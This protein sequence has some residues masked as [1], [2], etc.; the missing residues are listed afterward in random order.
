MKNLLKKI[1]PTQVLSIYH[2]FIAFSS[3][4]FY[5]Q[6]AKKLKII[7]V[8]GTK[9]KTST[10]EI[11]NSL[12][13]GAGYKTAI[14]STLRFKIDSDSKPN[15]LK[16]T[17]PGR[18]FLQKFLKEAL[19]KKVTHVIVEMS[20]EGVKQFRHSFID[21]DALVVTNLSPEHIEAHG[22][23]EHYALAKI[24]IVR[25]LIY[26]KKTPKI[27]VL[28]GDD[29]ES[30]RFEI[31]NSNPIKINLTETAPYALLADGLFFTYRGQKIQ[32]KLVG[33][34]NLYNILAS[35][36]IAEF[37][38]LDLKTIKTGIERLTS[39]PGRVEKISTTNQELAKKQNFTVIVDYA[40]TADSLEK[41]YR[42][43]KDKKK[44]CVLGSC[45][46]GRDKWKRPEMGKIA[47]KYCH[48]IILTDEDPYD[49]N[50]LEI[51]N[52]VKS[53]IN[54]TPTTITLDRRQAINQALTEARPT[55]VV[56]ITGKG[57]DPYIMRKGGEQEDWSDAKVAREELEKVLQTKK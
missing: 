12:L 16:M 28:N 10:V 18:G 43:Y 11:I 17:T 15:L 14:A 7:G 36:K 2:F 19:E 47:D 45:G 53:G 40:H 24:K 30:K 39:I 38:G 41:V 50:P 56:I 33:E 54:Q 31:K 13:E 52:M 35:I 6:P 34:F 57:T 22:S 25:A 27:L 51:I 1:I 49:E 5:N 23:F 37:F 48:K 9:G 55:D 3:T 29:P 4:L 8:T 21:L 44:I 32:A 26:S 46:G 42:V 20:S